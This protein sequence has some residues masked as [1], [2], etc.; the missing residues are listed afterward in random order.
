MKDFKAKYRRSHY[1]TDAT[2]IRAVYL[3]N[4]EVIDAE[5]NFMGNPYQVFKQQIIEY[6]EQG[7]TV[8]EGIQTLARSTIFTSEEERFHEN[9]WSG[10]KAFKEEYKQFKELTKEKGR[11]TKLDDSKLKWDKDARGYV[12]D[13]KILISYENSPFGIRFTKL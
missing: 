3:N 1:K 9:F 12:Y 8:T 11:Y 6:K 5:L 2:Y 13:N 7:K 10:L 4:K